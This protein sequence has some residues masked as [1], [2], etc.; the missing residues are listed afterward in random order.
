[1]N[2]NLEKISNGTISSFAWF[3]SQFSARDTNQSS[4]G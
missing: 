1:V 2:N 3:I 4:L